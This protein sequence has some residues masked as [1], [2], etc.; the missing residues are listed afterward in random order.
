[1][2]TLLLRSCGH[3]EEQRSAVTATAWRPLST[4]GAKQALSWAGVCFPGAYRAQGPEGLN[5]VAGHRP[6]G[7]PL[8][9]CQTVR[10]YVSELCPRQDSNLRSR[11]RSAFPSTALTCGFG[12]C[13]LVWGAY[14]AHLIA[15]AAITVVTVAGTAGIVQWM[16][17]FSVVVMPERIQ[18]RQP[19]LRV[20]GGALPGRRPARALPAPQPRV[21][22]AHK[23]IPGTVV[24]MA[25]GSQQDATRVR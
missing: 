11:L 19:V 24:T 3:G 18:E 10:I 2:P 21:T 13:P 4:N 15:L 9:D 20:Y 8:Q 16:K 22:G 14:G 5:I 23:M 1:V 17:R 7:F 25:A 12:P 6:G